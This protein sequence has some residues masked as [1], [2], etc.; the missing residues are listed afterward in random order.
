M[1]RINGS[2][3]AAAEK[4]LLVWIAERLPR[5]V[6]S[7][8][9]TAFGVAGMALTGAGFTLARLDQRGLILV[10]VGLAC[11]WFGDSLDGTVARVRKVERPRYGYYV[12]HALD[13]AGIT[14]LMAGLAASGYMTPM[15]AMAVL[16]AYLLVMGET[17]L[18]TS[19]S[20][21]FRMSVAGVGPTELRIVLAAG[22]MALFND[23]R[24]FGH[25][26]FDVGG[27]IATTGMGGA[28]VVAVWRNARALSHEERKAER[29]TKDT[30]NTKELLGFS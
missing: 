27:V 10:V 4:R 3:T 30:K 15:V 8:L 16:V 2:V 23:P 21:V 22:A 17:F 9:L 5:W 18:S 13:M 1:Q 19:V 7:D 12:D 26:L 29:A 20:N 24:P 11:N 14:M 28:F 6:H 25:Y